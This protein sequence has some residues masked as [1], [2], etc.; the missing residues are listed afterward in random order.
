MRK[1]RLIATVLLLAA[2]LATVLCA[3]WPRSVPLEECSEAYRSH[4]GSSHIASAYLKDFRVDDTVRVGVTVLEA[5]DSAGWAQLLLDYAVPSLPP[6]AES[7]MTE[8]QV[9][10]RY[11]AREDTSLPETGPHTGIDLLVFSYAKLTLSIFHIE[12]ET[13][14]N[15]ILMNQLNKLKTR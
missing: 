10:I 3:L 1:H 13:Q 15:A 8:N 12:S 5:L 2:V 9:N 7:L 11:V 6:E 14:I 4:A